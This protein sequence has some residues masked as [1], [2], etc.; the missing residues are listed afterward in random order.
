MIFI[1]YYR[2]KTYD[3]DDGRGR[4]VERIP[5]VSW[6]LDKNERV[7]YYKYFRYDLLQFKSAIKFI[8]NIIQ[9]E[10]KYQINITSVKLRD[11]W[12]KNYIFN[13]K[14]KDYFDLSM[15]RDKDMIL[16][17]TNTGKFYVFLSEVG[18][19]ECSPD[20]HMYNSFDHGKYVLVVTVNSDNN[21][22][23]LLSFLNKD[24]LFFVLNDIQKLL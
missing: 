16:I 12:T 5:D 11:I 20:Y 8:E 10:E 6:I 22:S 4:N 21:F 1:T 3:N 14:Y 19:W 23:K 15:C 13:E 18:D 7:L 24:E 9:S 17:I 2:E